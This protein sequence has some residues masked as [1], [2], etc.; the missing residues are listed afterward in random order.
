VCEI[1]IT[2]RKM[3]VSTT[4]KIITIVGATGT[5]G[6]SVAREFLSL[7]G[8]KV[9]CIT[10][11]PFSEKAQSLAALGAA[12][13]KADLDD[14]ASLED[15]FDGA[16]AI[17]VNTDFWNGYTIN[18]SGQKSYD[19]EVRQGKNAADAAS[20]VATLERFV[21]SA[22]GPMTRASGGKYPHSF[23]WES[24]ATIVDYITTQHADG[25]ARKLSLIYLGAYSTNAFLL[26][27]PDP[28]TGEYSFV[29]PMKE[30]DRMPVIDAAS[31]TGRF[32]RALMID[33]EIGTKLLA[34]DTDS[35]LSMGEL[36]KIWSRLTG[37]KAKFVQMGIQAIHELTGISMEVLDGPAFVS[38][39]GF[40]GGIDSYIEPN[41]LKNRIVTTSYEEF[42]RSKGEDFLLNSQFP[43]L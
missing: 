31:S 6:S 41:Q 40:M 13:V 11:S 20:R 33:E 9:R 42:L 35:Y 16:H 32:V 38:E 37:K 19:I 36:V 2:L 24:K 5:Q 10:R 18:G 22:L 30:S 23:H 34:Y 15:A 12:V 25:L 4:T 29:I 28:K 7:E 21:Y 14:M 3:Q 1:T 39:F 27:K 17:F 26:P 8:W 43:Q